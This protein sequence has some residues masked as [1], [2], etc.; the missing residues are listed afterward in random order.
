MKTVAV[1]IT[2]IFTYLNQKSR[3][4]LEIVQRSLVSFGKARGSQAAAGMAYY[5]FF[6]L[7]PLML[8]FIVVGSYFLDPGLVQQRILTFISQAVPNSSDLIQKNLDQVLALRSTVGVI[9]TISLL[10]SATGVFSALA[11]NINLAWPGA[12]ARNFLKKR[13]VGL[14]MV[15]VIA[16]LFTLAITLSMLGSIMPRFEL[17]LESSLTLYDTLIWKIV[18]TIMPWLLIFLMFASLYR[19]TPTVKVH[20]KAAAWSAMLSTVAWVIIT[21]GFTWY[22]DV[23][24][25]RYELVYGSLGAVV[26][27]MFLIYLNAMVT[28]YGAHLCASIMQVNPEKNKE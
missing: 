17:P 6:S 2:K 9:G 13:L 20:T 11:Y 5:A 7:F 12:P 26:A 16:L 24:L 22:L 8:L 14:G 21:R 27:L 3:G 28:L 10:W 1:K 25:G 23:G 19:W 4:R 18:T 15:A